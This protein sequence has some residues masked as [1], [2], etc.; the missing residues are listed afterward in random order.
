M[1]GDMGCIQ[2]LKEKGKCC[3]EKGKRS[4]A[5]IRGQNRK[6]GKVDMKGCCNYNGTSWRRNVATRIRA[7]KRSVVTRMGKA[8]AAR[9]EGVLQRE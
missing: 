7:R 5:T 9:H 6:Q 1:C 2:I 8:R 3:N 4:V